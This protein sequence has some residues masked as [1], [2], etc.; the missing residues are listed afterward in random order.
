M[1]VP[2]ALQDTLWHEDDSL[3]QTVHGDVPEQGDGD[4]PDDSAVG[5]CRSRGSRALPRR[6]RDSHPERSVET[7]GGSQHQER[8]PPSVFPSPPL[9]RPTSAGGCRCG[10]SPKRRPSGCRLCGSNATSSRPCSGR[11]TNGGTTGCGPV[12]PCSTCSWGIRQG[13]VTA[14]RRGGAG[15]PSAGSGALRADHAVSTGRR[16]H[17]PEVPHGLFCIARRASAHGSPGHLADPPGADSADP[18]RSRRSRRRPRG[19]AP[20]G[21]R[22]TRLTPY[23]AFPSGRVR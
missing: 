17:L 6:P 16:S 21:A 14:A 9:A 1:C 8:T 12:R 2:R 19:A 22:P 20:T 15:P 5:A 13:P 11:P 7:R 23:R 18:A 4:D 10:T 3:F